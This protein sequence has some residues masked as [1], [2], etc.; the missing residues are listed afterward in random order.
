MALM[1]AA[2][3]GGYR[4]SP[5]RGEHN[6]IPREDH[7]LGVGTKIRAAISH[8]VLV[9]RDCYRSNCFAFVD[10]VDCYWTRKAGSLQG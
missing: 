4:R 8:Q 3:L 6:W 9:T 10:F 5:W 2:G 7:E 1:E